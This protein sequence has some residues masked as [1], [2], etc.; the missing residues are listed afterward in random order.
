MQEFPN[1]I[2]NFV[3]NHSE[4]ALGEESFKAKFKKSFLLVVSAVKGF[5]FFVAHPCLLPRDS[6]ARAGE[7]ARG[8]C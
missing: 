4:I 3:L 1:Y 6:A 7:W 5:P 8:I 2:L